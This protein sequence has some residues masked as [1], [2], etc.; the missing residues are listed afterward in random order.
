MDFKGKT[1]TAAHYSAI[2]IIEDMP[3]KTSLRRQG[4]LYYVGAGVAAVAVYII[5]T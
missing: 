4:G 1:A 5:D 2:N 3:Q